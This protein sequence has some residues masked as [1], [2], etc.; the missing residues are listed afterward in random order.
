MPEDCGVQLFFDKI[1]SF[2]KVLKS[3][4]GSLFGFNSISI[5]MLT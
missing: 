2:S 4:I 5:S 1:I 3:K